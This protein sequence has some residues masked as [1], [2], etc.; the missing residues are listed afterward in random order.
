MPTMAFGSCDWVL[1]R[2]R[3]PEP[4]ETHAS[5]DPRWLGASGRSLGHCRGQPFEYRKQ[6]ANWGAS[7]LVPSRGSGVNRRHAFSST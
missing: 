6:I 4:G 3:H 1:C 7:K 2:R 5:N